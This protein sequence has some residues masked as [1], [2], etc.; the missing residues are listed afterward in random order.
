MWLS[1]KERKIE[2]EKRK[3][4]WNVKK[5]NRRKTITIL[6]LITVSFVHEKCYVYAFSMMALCQNVT[7][8]MHNFFSNQDPFFDHKGDRA[9]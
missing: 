5:R 6:S 7:G 8:Y 4:D 3:N 1:S 9:C 2:T